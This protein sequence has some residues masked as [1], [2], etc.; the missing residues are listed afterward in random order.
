MKISVI[1]S[2]FNESI[3]VI[4]LCIDSILNQSIKNFE[5]IIV[6][7]N[8]NSLK[9]Y[10]F[11][12]R[13]ENKDTRIQIL[14]NDTNLGL[15]KS[16]NRGLNYSTGDYIARVDADDI[17]KKSRLENQLEFLKKNNLDFV[18]SNAKII[19]ENGRTIHTRAL[20]N[21]KIVSQKIIKFFF[22]RANFSV[23]SSWFVKK[24]VFQSLHNYRNIDYAEDYDFILRALQRKIRIGYQPK[25]MVS[26]RIRKDSITKKN[27]YRQYVTAVLLSKNV[28]PRIIKNEVH[29]LNDSIINKVNKLYS[30]S[31]T[32]NKKKSLFILLKLIIYILSSKKLTIYAIWILNG[33]IIRKIT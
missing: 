4:K 3:D 11:L 28:P 5:Y 23:H 18:C 31:D 9:L 30:L 17:S 21:R 33:K 20:G 27:A 19:D 25:I 24:K 22:H 29:I 10:N 26:K 15:V 2:V 13:E 12:K 1:T 32:F 7:D 8:P 14:R 16:L 6:D